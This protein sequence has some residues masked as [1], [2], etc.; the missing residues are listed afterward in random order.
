MII[1]SYVSTSKFRHVES[2]AEVCHWHRP[3]RREPFIKK[4]LPCT[5]EARP[6]IPPADEG[7]RR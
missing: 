1:L 7:Q 6:N 5:T 3:A 2:S 4:G